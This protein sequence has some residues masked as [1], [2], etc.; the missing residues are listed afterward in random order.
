MAV[1]CL[2]CQFNIYVI[3]R[4]TPNLVWQAKLLQENGHLDTV[5]CL[6]GVCKQAWVSTSRL[7][8]PPEHDTHRGEC[9]VCWPF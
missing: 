9:R 4:T 6:G 2:E 5:W 3:R 8:I 1:V 7:V